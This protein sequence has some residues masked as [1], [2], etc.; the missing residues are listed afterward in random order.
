MVSTITQYFIISI[1]IVLICIFVSKIYGTT[2]FDFLESIY[3]LFFNRPFLPYFDPFPRRLPPDYLNI[4]KANSFYFNNLPAG[5]QKIFLKRLAK[6]IYDK[7]FNAKNELLLTK[8]MLVIAS[9]SAV[10]LTFGLRKYKLEAFHQIN[11]FKGEFYSD[12]AKSNVKGITNTN[13]SVSVSYKD[14]IYGI[15]DNRDNI[16]L[17]LHEFA[18]ALMLDN[19]EDRDLYFDANRDLLDDYFAN[20]NNLQIIKDRNLLRGYAFR[21][22][23]EFFSVA[24]EIFFETP[25]IMSESIPELYRMLCKMLNQDPLKFYPSESSGERR[26]ERTENSSV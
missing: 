20:K 6:F 14:L 11:F 24:V 2:I 13:G 17:G 9:E 18:H 23:L 19:S 1:V 26:F 25:D 15:A 4:L 21:N 10:R 3:I 5:K 16:N 12:L 7:D 8:E 22:K